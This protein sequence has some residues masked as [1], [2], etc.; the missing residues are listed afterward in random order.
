[1]PS[2]LHRF[3]ADFDEPEAPEEVRAQPSSPDGEILH[4]LLK[5]PFAAPRAVPKQHL[6]HRAAQLPGNAPPQYFPPQYFA[7]CGHLYCMYWWPAQPFNEGDEDGHQEGQPPP[8][9]GGEERAE[10]LEQA[11]QP[12]DRPRTTTRYMTKYE[13]ARIL[14][15]RALQIRCVEVRRSRVPDARRLTHS[16]CV[17]RPCEYVVQ[18]GT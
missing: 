1:M 7:V 9:E 14:G 17:A 2:T 11:P 4:M 15:T 5:E 3:E 6:L 12:S 10:V 16:A 8:P 18:Q 13:R